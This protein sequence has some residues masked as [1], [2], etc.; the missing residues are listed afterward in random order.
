VYLAYEFVTGTLRAVRFALPPPNE[1]FEK[2]VGTPLEDLSTA[3]PTRVLYNAL[4][5]FA[6]AA[7]E[8]FFCQSFKVL[9]HYDPSA[10]KHLRKQTRKIELADALAIAAR[11]KTIEDV[12]ADWYSFQNI[13]SIHGAFN[14]WFG[15]DVWELLRQR[16]KAGKRVGILERRLDQ[17]IQFRHGV[18]HG[19]SIDREM[20]KQQIEEV[21]DLA[22]V[23]IDVFVDHLEKRYGTRVRDV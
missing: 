14:E 13:A 17:L 9:L 20:R 7:L 12:V 5:P 15:I 1:G 4:V 21:L 16:K 6:V 19:L 22:A 18:I 8:H 2:L 10:I 23:I 11:E 3:D